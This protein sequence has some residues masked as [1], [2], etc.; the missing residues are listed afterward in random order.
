VAL[1]RGVRPARGGHVRGGAS[2]HCLLAADRL[3]GGRGRRLPDHASGCRNNRRRDLGGP[4]GLFREHGFGSRYGAGLAAHCPAA[5][6]PA[7]AARDPAVL[8][9]H[10]TVGKRSVGEFIGRELGRFVL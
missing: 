9:D 10:D 1:A 2:R 5:R 4:D 3:G 8:D 6:D 7:G